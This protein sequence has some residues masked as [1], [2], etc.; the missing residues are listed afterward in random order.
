LRTG[1]TAGLANPNLKERII[2]LGGIPLPLSPADF[3]KL[4]ADET[5]KWG[6]VVKLSGAKAN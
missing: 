4:I 3:G 6:K 2:G 1:P 5:E